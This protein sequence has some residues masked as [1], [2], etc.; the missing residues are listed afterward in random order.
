MSSDNGSGRNMTC[1]VGTWATTSLKTYSYV[2][3]WEEGSD[4][5]FN[6]PYPHLYGEN[7]QIPVE[8]IVYS[9][10]IVYH[11]TYDFD[12]G[13]AIGDVTDTYTVL[14]EVTLPRAHKDGYDFI[15][16]YEGDVPLE[17]I[18]KGTF[19]DIS[20]K[21]AYDRHKPVIYASYAYFDVEER[22]VPLSELL[23]AMNVRAIDEVDGDISGNIIVSYIRYEDEGRTVNDPAYLDTGKSQIVTVGL[24]VENSGGKSAQT[25]KHCYILGKGE[26]IDRQ[27]NIKV[28]S[29]FISEEYK[30]TLSAGSIWRNADYRE[31]LEAA[32][33]KARKE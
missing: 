4:W 3:S 31:V 22:H 28:Y 20:L 7:S 13:E 25:E 33:T 24:S 21:A 14:D 27:D 8:R 10:P 6:E 16:W 12:G 17:K 9:R 15:G 32:Y 26:D 18:E 23:S 11:I 5:R 2:L 30:E 19:R 1:I 29:R